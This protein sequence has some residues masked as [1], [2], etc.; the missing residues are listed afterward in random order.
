M[1]WWVKA[2]IGAAI[3]VV[4]AALT[5]VPVRAVGD[6]VTPVSQTAAAAQDGCGAITLEAD[7]ESSGRAPVLDVW[8]L[9]R[10]DVTM[11]E[12]TITTAATDACEDDVVLT[13]GV[14]VFD[15][16]CDLPVEAPEELDAG[17]DPGAPE[18]RCG[19]NGWSLVPWADSFAL[20]DLVPGGQSFAYA[21]E[22]LSLGSSFVL[23]DRW[24]AGAQYFIE[25][26]W[27]GTLNVPAEEIATGDLCIATRPAGASAR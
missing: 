26:R 3:V 11:V 4:V 15:P 14:L 7:L 19:G 18:E 16:N 21:G 22:R 6:A 2:G 20:E 13:G 8:G 1:A 27:G 17:L 5:V 23:G 25:Q 24:C 10:V 12:P 9:T